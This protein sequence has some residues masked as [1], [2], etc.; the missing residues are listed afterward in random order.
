MRFIVVTNEWMSAHGLIPLPTMRKS[1]DGTKVILHEDFF[2]RVGIDVSDMPSYGHN[3]EE[4]EALL[5]GEEW[6]PSEE[7]IPTESADYIQVAAIRNLMSVT[8]EGIQAMS[9]T[10]DESL[11]VKDVYPE[12]EEYINGSLSQGMKV[13]HEG[14]LYKVL[15][16]VNPVLSIYPP[17]A[18][19]TEALYAVINE[20]HAGTQEDPIPY[21]QNMVLEKGKY[22]T[23]Y[24][25]MYEC[26]MTTLTGYPND[27][28]ELSSVVKAVED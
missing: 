26:I 24:G 5:Q 20:S 16:A 25:V 27:L 12:W 15:Q 23:Q 10:D 6:S 3:S 4:L 19:G 17:G 28:Y 8:M 18:V 7:D 1:K 11:K 2:V 22:Y 13:Q 14:K 21:E 9:L